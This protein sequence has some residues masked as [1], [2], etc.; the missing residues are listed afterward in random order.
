MM[1]PWVVLSV[2]VLVA[3]AS[4]RPILEVVV[5]VASPFVIEVAA[6]VPAVMIEAMV[7]VHAAPVGQQA[8]YPAASALQTAVLAQHRPGAPRSLHVS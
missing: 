3:L 1:K 2:V 6:M 4:T 7:P 5:I 8:T